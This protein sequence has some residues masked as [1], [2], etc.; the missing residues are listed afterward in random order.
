MKKSNEVV[1]CYPAKSARETNQA[2][3]QTNKIIY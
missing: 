1:D 3:K 2:N